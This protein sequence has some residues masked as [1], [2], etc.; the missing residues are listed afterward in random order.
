M[1]F[2]FT[3][4]EILNILLVI[5]FSSTSATKLNKSDYN[6]IKDHFHLGTSRIIGGHPANHGNAVLCICSYLKKEFKICVCI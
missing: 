3:P 2:R 4:T 6:R 1:M 5:V